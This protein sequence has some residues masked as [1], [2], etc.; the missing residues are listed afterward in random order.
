MEGFSILKCF[1]RS[2]HFLLL[3]QI[4]IEWGNKALIMNCVINDNSVFNFYVKGTIFFVII[5]NLVNVLICIFLSL[6]YCVILL[7]L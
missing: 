5:F 1:C 6:I 4:K 2:P 3:L 7:V